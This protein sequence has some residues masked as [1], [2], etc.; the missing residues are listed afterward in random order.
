MPKQQLAA[1]L[2][3]CLAIQ[4][5]ADTPAKVLLPFGETALWAASLDEVKQC[6]QGKCE[7]ESLMGVQQAMNYALN[8]ARVAM[9]Y[10]EDKKIKK[11]NFEI[12]DKMIV[13]L[14]QMS[15]IEAGSEEIFCLLFH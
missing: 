15:D 4:V 13:K 7:E 10:V 5:L 9:K 3:S 14:A 11:Q 8:N 1:I 12:I 2:L 6:A